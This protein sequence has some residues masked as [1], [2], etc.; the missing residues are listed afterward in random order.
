MHMGTNAVAGHELDLAERMWT[1]SVSWDEIEELLH[2]D[3]V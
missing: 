1:R 3:E 2:L